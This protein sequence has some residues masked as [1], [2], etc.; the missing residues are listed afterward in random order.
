MRYLLL[1]S[2]IAFVFTSCN[3][4]QF[5][6]E[7]AEVERLQLSVDS[8]EM[9]FLSWNLDSLNRAGKAINKRVEEAVSLINA[10]DMML[11][12]DQSNLMADFKAASKAFKGMGKD[13]PQII[14]EIEVSRK[15]LSTLKL[16]LERNALEPKEA[17]EYLVQE[18]KAAA[19]LVATVRRINKGFGAS[20]ARV[21]AL[22]PRVDVL[23]EELRNK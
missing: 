13:M 8:A 16:D 22:G 2:A 20:K 7:V 9:I 15:Q 12:I 6:E 11:D 19:N 10:K 3:K 21:E 1:L 4:T 17:A 18:K 14:G 23:I 5:K